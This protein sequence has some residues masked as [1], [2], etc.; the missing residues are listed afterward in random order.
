M[1]SKK[2]LLLK[3]I[4]ELLSLNV[5]VEEITLNLKEVGVTEQQAK[6]LIQEAKNPE[7]SEKQPVQPVEMEK[8]KATK[9]AAKKV[10]QA[11]EQKKVEQEREEVTEQ[12]AAEDFGPEQQAD[13]IAEALSLKKKYASKQLKQAPK[14]QAAAEALS[15]P[16]LTPTAK[17]VQDINISKLWEKGI[18]GTVNQR[19]SEMKEIKRDIDAKLDQKVEKASKKEL[20]KI[21]VLFD[22]QRALMVS[23]V[24]SELEAKAR[25]FAQMIEAKLQEMKAISQTI[26]NKLETLKTREE[27]TRAAAQALTIQLKDLKSTKDELLSSFNSEL[28]ESKTQ[29]KKSLDEMGQKLASMDARI[30]KTL[31]LENQIAEGLVKGAEQTIAQMIGQKEAELSKTGSEAL[32][33]FK[34][35]MQAFKTEQRQKLAELAEQFHSQ[36]QQLDTKTDQ[37]LAKLDELQK[38]ITTEFK[39]G[40]FRQQMKELEEFKTQFVEAI[41]ENTKRFNTGIKKINTQSQTMEKQFM[42]RAEKIDKKI[43]ELDAFEKN[44]AK[45]IGVSLEKLTKK[46]GKK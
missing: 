31:Q 28:I 7:A 35:L 3:S 37:R 24:D 23:K 46:K 2:Q 21:K 34:N 9:K 13:T 12:L 11:E 43:V 18:L 29:A 14:R 30:N 1:L 44:F 38:A 20:D 15:Q 19:L 27:K 33:E 25:D 26:D 36:M 10:L 4:R 8:P 5:P 40:Q 22:S 17:L 39:P 16:T 41:E 45:E 42:L 32:E 6:K